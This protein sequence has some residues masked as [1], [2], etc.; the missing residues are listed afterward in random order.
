[1]EEI[2]ADAA[3]R[4]VRALPAEA[5]FRSRGVD[6]WSAADD[7]RIE[8]ESETDAAPFTSQSSVVLMQSC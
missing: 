7:A 3:V 4:P 2:V 5:S 6:Y 8:S 1:M